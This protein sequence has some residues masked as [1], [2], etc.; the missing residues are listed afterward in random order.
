LRGSG[1]GR[2]KNDAR[3]SK[4]ENVE[5]RK[6]HT[7]S[8]YFQN[9]LNQGWRDAPRRLAKQL[10]SIDLRL[11]MPRGTLFLRVRPSQAEVRDNWRGDG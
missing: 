2:G 6:L 8:I 5:I 7:S 10:F 4:S 11:A 3:K 9:Q 1:V